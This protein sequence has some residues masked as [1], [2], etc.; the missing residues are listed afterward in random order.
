MSIYNN[1]NIRF[2]LNLGI[3][4]ILIGI[5]TF[6]TT[7]KIA[8]Q[9]HKIYSMVELVH[10]MA[11]EINELKSTKP[12]NCI[13]ELNK[14]SLIDVSDVDDSE[15]IHNF[16]NIEPDDEDE[17]EEEEE[18]EEEEEED[19]EEDDDDNEDVEDIEIN[20]IKNVA[21]NINNLT[22]ILLTFRRY[23]I[24]QEAQQGNDHSLI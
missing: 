2:F 10:S 8:E 6:Y 21:K 22:L 1:I 5:L 7:Q 20:I 18:D 4:L 3:C 13:V 11:T 19:E 17:E 24:C 9:N 16:E 23:L 15:L 14:N 12:S